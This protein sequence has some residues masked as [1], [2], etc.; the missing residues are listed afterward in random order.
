[1]LSYERKTFSKYYLTIEVNNKIC[2]T[3]MDSKLN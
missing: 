2:L 3:F 1:M